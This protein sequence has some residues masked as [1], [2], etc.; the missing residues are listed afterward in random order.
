[1]GGIH[2]DGTQGHSALTEL[3]LTECMVQSSAWPVLLRRLPRLTRITL[4]RM[5]LGD[6]KEADITMLAVM[7]AQAVAARRKPISTDFSSAL[8]A[9]FGAGSGAAF[10]AFGTATV[11]Q[12]GIWVVG[13]QGAAGSEPQ[14]AMAGLVQQDVQDAG[15]SGLTTGAGT[16]TQGGVQGGDVAGPSGIGA[17]SASAGP[18]A[19]AGPAGSHQSDMGHAAVGQLAHGPGEE[20]LN[21]GAGKGAV[22]GAGVGTASDAAQL[23]GR[24]AT[25][26]AAGPSIPALQQAMVPQ[27]DTSVQAGAPAFVLGAGPSGLMPAASALALQPTSRARSSVNSVERDTRPHLEL[28]VHPSVLAPSDVGRVQA[29]VGMWGVGEP[30]WRCVTVRTLPVP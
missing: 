20:Q 7:A 13:G 18:G 11:P 3:T 10:A 15:P 8:G 21:P 14:A 23:G 1:M 30:W 25:G 24:Q 12:G 27:A 6:V 29:R 5:C 22:A 26:A 16:G 17:P 2:A 19:G 4:G 28:L 9:L